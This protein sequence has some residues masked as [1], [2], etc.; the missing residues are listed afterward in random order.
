V[1]TQEIISRLFAVADFIEARR[2]GASFTE[3][4]AAFPEHYPDVGNPSIARMLYRDLDRLMD[5]RAYTVAT[6]E[7][8]QRVF[9]LARQATSVAA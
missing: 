6:R 3:I 9:V 1:T 8:N 5:L 2:F 7:D 4:A